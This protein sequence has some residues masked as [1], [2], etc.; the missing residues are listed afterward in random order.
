M[1]RL[2]SKEEKERDKRRYNANKPKREQKILTSFKN[3][4][5]NNLRDVIE[6]DGDRYT[7][8]YPI[9]DKAGDRLLLNKGKSISED[10]LR[11]MELSNL[12]YQR[13]HKKSKYYFQ[14]RIP[15]MTLD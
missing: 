10:R 3:V 9:Y 11:Q 8:E 4:D 1:T 14:R 6:R 13:T 12:R 5:L 15:E 7:A 2:K